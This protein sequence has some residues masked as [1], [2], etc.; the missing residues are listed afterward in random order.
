MCRRVRD[1]SLSL[2]ILDRKEVLIL[3]S[4]LNDL[5]AVQEV[6][7]SVHKMRINVLMLGNI[8]EM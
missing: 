7:G 1:E 5:S 6:I 2:P 8:P 4:P 3:F